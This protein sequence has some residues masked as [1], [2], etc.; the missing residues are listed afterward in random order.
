MPEPLAAS[1]RAAWA[2]LVGRRQTAIHGDLHSANLMLDTEGR[3]VLID[4]DEARR[5]SPLFDLASIA[6]G[7][8][9]PVLARARLAWEVAA[10]WRTE[11]TYA[12][13]LAT[14][15]LEKA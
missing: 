4:W 13:A 1:C 7:P 5:D 2:P 11:P 6:T 8:A 14:R 12:K 9:S 3:P 10:G 15:L